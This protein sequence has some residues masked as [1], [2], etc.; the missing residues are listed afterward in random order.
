MAIHKETFKQDAQPEVG[1]PEHWVI[2][3]FED[4]ESERTQAA[5]FYSEKEARDFEKE[6]EEL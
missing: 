5:Y 6:L 4:E 1:I 3:Y 2:L